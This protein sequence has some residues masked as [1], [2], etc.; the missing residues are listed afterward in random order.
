MT[1]YTPS[2]EIK[3]LGRD[4]NYNFKSA[5]NTLNGYKPPVSPLPYKDQLTG[6]LNKSYFA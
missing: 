3:Y 5:Y 6:A 2:K 4:F 1:E